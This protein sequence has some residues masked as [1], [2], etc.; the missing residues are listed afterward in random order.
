VDANTIPATG[1]EEDEILEEL[2][3]RA[4]LEILFADFRNEPL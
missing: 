3:D 2:A 1:V 4:A